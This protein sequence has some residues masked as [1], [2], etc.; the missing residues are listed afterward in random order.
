M[1]LKF[2]IS[3]K[4]TFTW[5]GACSSIAKTNAPKINQLDASLYTCS[6]DSSLNI[7]NVV[8]KPEALAIQTSFRF[9]ANITNPPIVVK[10]VDITVRAVK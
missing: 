4:K 9:T 10:N 7:I 1:V 3:S 5:T 2:L 8:L 6:I